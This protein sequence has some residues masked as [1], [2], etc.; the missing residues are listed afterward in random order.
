MRS[1]GRPATGRM[2]LSWKNMH[3]KFIRM[4]TGLVGSNYRE[5][6]GLFF[7]SVKD[8]LIEMHKTTKEHE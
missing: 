6:L 8:D 7:F 4:L 3:K 2:S 1:A 5:R